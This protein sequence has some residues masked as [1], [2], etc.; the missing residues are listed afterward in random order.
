MLTTMFPPKD[1][2]ITHLPLVE[3]FQDSFM[4]TS[5][6]FMKNL[7]NEQCVITLIMRY[8]TFVKT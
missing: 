5:C 3:C 2:I 7:N 8:L 4:S 6:F 1:R